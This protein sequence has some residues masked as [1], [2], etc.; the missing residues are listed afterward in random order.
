MHREEGEKM[1]H[2]AICIPAT[3]RGVTLFSIAVAAHKLSGNRQKKWTLRQFFGRADANIVSCFGASALLAESMGIIEDGED[4]LCHAGLFG[5]YASAMSEARAEDWLSELRRKTFAGPK[6]QQFITGMSQQKLVKRAMYCCQHCMQEDEAEHGLA[7]WHTV[8]QIP[9]IYHCPKH[10]ES[11]L[12]AC[13][14]C[15]RSQGSDHEWNLPALTC[16]HCGAHCFAE[17]RQRG[18]LG[19]ARHLSL[20][21]KVCAGNGEFLRPAARAGL[22]ANAF[23]RDAGRN[24]QAIT[25][26]LL[27]MWECVNFAELSAAVGTR[28]T[29]RFVEKAIRGEHTGVNPIAHLSLISLAELNMKAR[30]KKADQTSGLVDAKSE[31]PCSL[32]PL[33]AALEVAGLP[34]NL[35]DGLGRG[36]SLTKMS[37]AEGIPYPRLRRQVGMLLERSIDE[38]CVTASDDP[39]PRAIKNNL[40]ALAE[41][42]RRPRRRHNRFHRKDSV[43]GLEELRALNRSKVNRYLEQG[44]RTRKQ[45][46]YKNS[47]LGDWCR[48]FDS[49][50]FQAV[51]PA[52]PQ[53]ER[54]GVGRRKGG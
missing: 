51:L 31:Y 53:S 4:L 29:S 24:L 44:I 39:I 41:K 35:A 13:L 14:G 12:G 28:I 33:K 40:Q 47:D 30:C 21:Q 16:P 27:D 45:L 22:F 2:S 34:V 43:E 17:V 18:S 20:V 52:I 7:F 15:G 9:G 37:E 19:Y 42:L 25:N 48:Q 10:N 3:P 1:N 26:G 49:E 50:W 38:L 5:F 6:P 11:L 46:H 32:A 23:G 54:K 8:H 36:L